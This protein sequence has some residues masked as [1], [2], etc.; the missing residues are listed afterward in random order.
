MKDLKHKW[1][2]VR[3]GLEPAGGDCRARG[4]P[5]LQNLFN[6][7]LPGTA[8][9]GQPISCLLKIF[10]I[11]LLTFCQDVALATIAMQGEL[12]RQELGKYKLSY[13]LN[14]N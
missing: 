7:G 10:R 5:L 2:H 4:R 3:R 14:L 13:K 8:P 12:R 9:W 11:D 1:E 6:S